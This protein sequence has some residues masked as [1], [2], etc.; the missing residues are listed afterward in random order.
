LRAHTN[1]VLTV[2]KNTPHFAQQHK[3][4][5]HSR[6]FHRTKWGIILREH[7]HAQKTYSRSLYHA[8]SLSG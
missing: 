7:V 3:S 6:Y 1:E 8:A 2:K 5:Y 4:T